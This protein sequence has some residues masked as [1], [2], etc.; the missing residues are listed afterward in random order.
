MELDMNPDS[1]VEH[2]AA[3]VAVAVVTV[4]CDLVMKAGNVIICLESGWHETHQFTR[5]QTKTTAN[6]IAKLR[7]LSVF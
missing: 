6:T 4:G 2:E 7:F 3:V 1:L 5:S